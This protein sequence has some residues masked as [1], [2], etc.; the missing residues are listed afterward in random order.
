MLNVLKRGFRLWVWPLRKQRRYGKVEEEKDEEE[1]N[2][3]EEEIK[4]KEEK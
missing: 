4:G 3:M 1:E 2:E